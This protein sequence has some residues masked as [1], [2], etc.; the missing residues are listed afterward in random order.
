MSEQTAAA[1][2]LLARVSEWKLQIETLQ[3]VTFDD[4]TNKSAIAERFRSAE[5]AVTFADKVLRLAKDKTFARADVRGALNRLKAERDD[6]LFVL[7][8]IAYFAAQGEWLNRNFPEGEWRDVE[9]LCKI[10][11]RAE[12]AEQNFSL[13]PGRYVGVSME[14]DGMTAADFREFTQ[15]NHAALRLLHAE[16]DELQTLIAEDLM[17]LF[18]EAKTEAV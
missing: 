10:A 17:S 16:A 13:N 18:S 5:E 9:G 7:E 3:S 6:A 11:S 1:D 14:D 12:I 8:R 2:E 4:L 15:T